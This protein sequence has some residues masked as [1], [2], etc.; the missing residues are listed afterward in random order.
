MID[1]KLHVYNEFRNIIEKSEIYLH[2]EFED[3]EEIAKMSARNKI[4]GFGS[5]VKTLSKSI[6][7]ENLDS[8]INEAADRAL[9][10]E[11]VRQLC[12]GV[13]IK[14]DGKSIGTVKSSSYVCFSTFT[15]RRLKK[16]LAQET[17]QKV[18]ESLGSEICTGILRYIESKVKAELKGD[19]IH[20]ELELTNEIFATFTIIVMAVLSFYFTSWFTLIMMV[21]SMVVVAVLTVDVN[22]VEWRRKVADEIYN[23]VRD[24]RSNIL[25]K[26]TPEIKALCQNTSKDLGTVAEKILK[27]RDRIQLIDKIESK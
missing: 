1:A 25:R 27:I 4:A 20:L 3:Y 22:S 9:T 23:K 21:G 11:N 2:H 26:V 12:F 5:M 17:L 18:G 7:I 10:Q 8:I 24:K 13:D 14:D 16:Y 6:P 19:L 15:V